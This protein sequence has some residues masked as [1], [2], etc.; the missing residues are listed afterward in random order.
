M[1]FNAQQFIDAK[2][3]PR[4]TGVPVPDLKQWFG[5]DEPVW[6]VRGLSGIE[7]GQC[8]EAAERNRNVAAILEGLISSS[9]KEKT[10]SVK[11]LLGVGD[12]SVPQ[13]VAKRLELL[14]RGSVSPPCD[15]ELA[16]KLCTAFPVEFFQITNTITKLTGQ[17]YEPGKPKPSG[18]TTA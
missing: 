7:L 9:S 15:L 11:E 4:E 16:K 14:M 10:T 5:E 17:G 2:L 6:V 12:G 1:P 18:G 13:D 3:V 8:N